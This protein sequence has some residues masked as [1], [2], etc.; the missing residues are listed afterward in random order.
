MKTSIKT[1]QEMGGLHDIRTY[2]GAVRKSGKPD[3]PTTAILGLYMRRNEKERILSELKRTRK[4]K[5]QLQKRLKEVETEMTKLLDKA[6]KTAV[7]IRG[8]SAK[9]SS[10]NSPLRKGRT[11]LGY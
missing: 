6:Q 5:V 2:T 4:R 11:V 1:I 3:L 8:T 9:S 7:E 10:T